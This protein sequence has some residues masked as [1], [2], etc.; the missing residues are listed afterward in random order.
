MLLLTA[1]QIMNVPFHISTPHKLTT[2]N[3]Y[4]QDGPSQEKGRRG[5]EKSK[6][7][8]TGGDKKKKRASRKIVEGLRIMKGKF[9]A[10]KALYSLKTLKMV[11]TKKRKVAITVLEKIGGAK[12]GGEQK[13]LVK[14]NKSYLLTKSLSACKKKSTCTEKSIFAEKEVKNVPSE[15]HKAD[16]KTVGDEVLN[17]TK[18]HPEVTTFSML[19]SGSVIEHE[20]QFV[21]VWLFDDL[22]ITFDSSAAE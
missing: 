15:Q 20:E 2:E 16:Q 6:L 11:R 4:R 9:S 5:T 10:R 12:N 7:F 21:A 1:I 3:S 22:R 19:S 8:K 13:V 17:A 14:K 18:T